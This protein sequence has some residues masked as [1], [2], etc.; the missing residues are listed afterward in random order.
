MRRL[1]LNLF[2]AFALAI[3][4]RPMGMLLGILS[5]TAIL[6]FLN[7]IQWRWSDSATERKRELESRPAMKKAADGM[8]RRGEWE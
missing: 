8:R 3:A 5:T 1:A 6:L 4:L 2:F 7:Y